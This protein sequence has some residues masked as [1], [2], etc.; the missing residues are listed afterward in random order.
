V[1]LLA[2]RKQVAVS[3]LRGA[4]GAQLVAV[5]AT[6]RSA[7]VKVRGGRARLTLPATRARLYIV[8]K[9]EV[10]AVLGAKKP[11]ASQSSLEIALISIGTVFREA[12]RVV[13]SRAVQGVILARGVS[14]KKK[15]TKT[16][17]SRVLAALAKVRAALASK[18]LGRRSSSA[19]IDVF[20]STQGD[21]DRDG[22]HD[23][24]DVD[25]DNDGVTDNYDS[26][27]NDLAP[28]TA[29][30]LGFIVFS[31]L[32]MPIDSSL[33]LFSTGLDTTRIDAALQGSQTLAIGVAGNPLN[34]LRTAEL[35]CTG[36]SYCSPGGTGAAIDSG[37]TQNFPDRNDKDEDGYGTITPGSTGDFQ[38]KTGAKFSE[39]AA[40]DVLTQI[41]PAGGGKESRVTALLNFIFVSVPALKAVTTSL[42]T[43]TID[44]GS[45][46]VV[47]SASN[48]IP[49]PA[50]GPVSI[51]IEGY[52]PQRPGVRSIREDEWVDIGGSRVIIDVPNTPVLTPG[53]GAGT[54]PGN[55][56]AA[57]YSTTD[58]NLGLEP[59][60]LRD[61]LSD[62]N[63]SP[64]NTYSF[65]IDLTD[66]LAGNPGGAIA[67]SSGEALFVDLQF[68]S[69]Y[70]DNAA[71]KF[72]V[73]R[74]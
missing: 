13:G 23:V 73:R 9:G 56:R 24:V 2:A 30:R 12:A 34:P 52:R 32:K 66:C 25:N 48:C 59:F 19:A 17:D 45:A 8:K 7:S 37:T 15:F 3:G 63:A 36:L 42:G 53:S 39:I 10:T 21:R 54:G 47:G 50:A 35:D 70:G 28:I 58:P 57:G 11:S 38:L 20:A 26:D 43:T 18:G 22:L 72:C 33:N 65:T 5:A 6:G 61:K 46:P 71:Q 29:G 55:C 64:T 62:R 27:S 14:S 51:T 74:Q 49:V 16:V 44:Y 67:W 60:G 1:R 31:N 4:N 69:E 40:G 41:V 68:R